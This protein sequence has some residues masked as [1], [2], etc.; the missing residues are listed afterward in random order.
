MTYK[1]RQAVVSSGPGGSSQV[2]IQFSD[3]GVPLGSTGTVTDV[4]FVG[5]S[6]AAT[7]SGNMLTVSIPTPALLLSHIADTANPHATTAAQV[8]LGNVDNTSDLNKP[9]ST[10]TQTA[11]NLK[12][13]ITSL[14]T[15]LTTTMNFGPVSA[16]RATSSVDITSLSGLTPASYIDAFPMAEA[17]A[18][19]SADGVRVDA[20]DYIGQYLSPTSVR[21]FGNV[22]RGR[23]YGDRTIRV[24]IR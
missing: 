16:R 13:D 5:N 14:P 19:H 2:N 22:R 9:I 15:Y 3:E 12:A 7:R 6:V 18:D 24:V 10:A 8:G 20:V 4:N 21:V 17:T 23:T 11:L 1:R